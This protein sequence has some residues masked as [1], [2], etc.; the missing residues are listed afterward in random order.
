MARRN[1]YKRPAPSPEKSRVKEVMFDIFEL[2]AQTIGTAM[3][4][5]SFIGILIGFRG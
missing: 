1:K 5:G 3:L 2:A 4:L